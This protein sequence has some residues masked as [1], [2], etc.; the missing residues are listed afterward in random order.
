MN[1]LRHGS[2]SHRFERG[3]EPVTAQ[4][5]LREDGRIRVLN[6]CHQDGPDGKVRAAEG[7]AKVVESCFLCS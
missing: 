1:R 3:C 4:Y 2:T 5:S 6:T 7:R